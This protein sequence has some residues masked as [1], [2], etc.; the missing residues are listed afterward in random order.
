MKIEQEKL[1]E[2]SNKLKQKWAGRTCPMCQKGNWI[3]QE[4][5]FQLIEFNNGSLVMGGPPTPL[6]IQ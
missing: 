4:N 3:I 6:E 5:C 1:Q 2:L